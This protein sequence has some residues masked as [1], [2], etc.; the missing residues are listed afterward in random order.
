M[1]AQN[2]PPE[3]SE[4]Q[5]EDPT[6]EDFREKTRQTSVWSHRRNPQGRAVPAA[7]DVVWPSFQ[8]KNK[9]NICLEPQKGSTK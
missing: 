8:R 3:S 4:K 2:R 9:T 1:R 7:A 5:N 6:A